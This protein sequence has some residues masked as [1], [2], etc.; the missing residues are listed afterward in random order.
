MVAKGY[1][2]VDREYDLVLE[3]HGPDKKG[4]TRWLADLLG[5]RDAAVEAVFAS[6]IGPRTLLSSDK[7]TA[8]AHLKALVDRGAE[9]AVH[10]G[11]LLY[12]PAI[13]RQE[14]VRDQ[15][16]LF[17]DDVIGDDPESLTTLDQEIQAR[18]A[19]TS[20]PRKR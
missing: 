14:S 6:T 2:R 15:V 8:Q 18:R 1:L 20:R 17:L 4:V 13:T 11:R 5:E 10:E 12:V 9:A 7:P 19:R 16:R 3:H